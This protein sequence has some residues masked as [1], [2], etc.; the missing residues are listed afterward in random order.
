MI[1]FERL[2]AIAYYYY[3]HRNAAVAGIAFIRMKTVQLSFSIERSA[4]GGVLS[5]IHFKAHSK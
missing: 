5:L 1:I 4:I 3:H 2:I